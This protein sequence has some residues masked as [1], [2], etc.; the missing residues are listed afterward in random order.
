MILFT[1][2]SNMF[3]MKA[4]T[5]QAFNRTFNDTLKLKIRLSK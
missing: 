4:C 1:F 2:Y 3:R 5:V